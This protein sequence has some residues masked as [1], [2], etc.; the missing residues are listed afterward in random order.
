M[1]NQH[2]K[3]SG[4]RE[5]T[6]VEIDL[7]N[8]IK[9]FGSQL[10]TLCEKVQAHIAQQR[11][12]CLNEAGTELHDSDEKARLDMA[13]PEKWAGWAKDCFQSNLMYLTR[14][15]AQPTSF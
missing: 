6:Q 4:Y 5:L 3:I 11:Q 13:E 14:A 10:Q 9:A 1:E 12:A 15:V 7:M 8:E 2:R